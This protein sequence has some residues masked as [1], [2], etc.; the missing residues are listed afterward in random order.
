VVLAPSAAFHASRAFEPSTAD[1]VFG[2]AF[3]SFNSFDSFL[4]SGKFSKVVNSSL[5][6]G[7]CLTLLLYI[8]KLIANVLF[9]SLLETRK[10]A[11]SYWEAEIRSRSWFRLTC[12]FGSGLTILR[13]HFAPQ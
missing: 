7:F 4:S 11:L 6:F 2:I 10:A 12:A 3:S 13:F 5:Q 9:S 1:L 8:P